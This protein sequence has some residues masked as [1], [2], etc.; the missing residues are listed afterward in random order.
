MADEAERIYARRVPTILCTA[1]VLAFLATPVTVAASTFVG[2]SGTDYGIDVAIDPAGF[3]YVAVNTSS[4][5]APTTPGAFQPNSA[6]GDE[7]FVAKYSPDGGTLI[8]GT[9]LGGGSYDFVSGIAVDGAGSAYVTG[10][11][12][13]ANFPATVGGFDPSYNGEGDAYVAKLSPD[14]E[15]LE[16]A[17]FLGGTASLGPE[18]GEAIAVDGSGAAYV[19]GRTGSDDFPVTPTAY[20][21]T[22]ATGSL[23]GFVTKVDPDGSD[24]AWSSYLGSFQFDWAKS[25]AVDGAG[26]PV[27]VGVTASPFF[28]TTLGAY[29]TNFSGGQDGFITRFN[30]SGTALSYSTFLGGAGDTSGFVYDEEITEIVLDGD[31][32][33]YVTGNT[34]APDFPT[35]PGSHDTTL[36]GPA[37]A[38]AAKL[39]STGESLAWSTYVGGGGEDFGGG[40]A[41]GGSGLAYAIGTTRSADLPIGSG[42]GDVSLGGLQDAYQLRLQQDGSA[43]T[44]GTFIG[45]SSSENGGDVALAPGELPVVVG[46]T[47]SADFPITPGAPDPNLSGDYDGFVMGFA[48]AGGAVDLTAPNTRLKGPKRVEQGRKARFRFKSSEPGSSFLCKL[49]KKK[50]KPCSSP[51]KVR[52]GKLGTDRRHRFKVVAVD[53]AGNVDP[54]PAKRRFK[55]KEE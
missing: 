36:G 51:R 25:L 7:A 14:G 37:D 34:P 31:G 35:T 29:D 10:E 54:T 15:S 44:D 33:A 48:G 1:V 16:Y 32:A 19:T 30:S 47:G 39:G 53:A 38:F 12:G 52:T 21:Q 42:G 9:Y 26:R 27:V 41:V 11:T 40:I 18:T 13:S 22:F 49:D 23:D 46:S 5:D 45:G 55:V 4:A 24:L 8:Y 50:F 6:G 3:V 43:V 28:P 20:D 2:G 17:G